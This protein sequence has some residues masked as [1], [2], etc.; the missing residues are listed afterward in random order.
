V[1][2]TP[3]KDRPSRSSATTPTVSPLDG[4]DLRQFLCALACFIPTSVVNW[5]IAIIVTPR[6]DM[7]VKPTVVIR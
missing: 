6:T 3:D 5:L 7:R 4:H 1:R 2:I